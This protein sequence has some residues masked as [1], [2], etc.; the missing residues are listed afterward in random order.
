MRD[1][2]LPAIPT[3]EI[4]DY[5]VKME[6]KAQLF[7]LEQGINRNARSNLNVNPIYPAC[8]GLDNII[9]ATSTNAKGRDV[10]SILPGGK[11]G[12]QSGTSI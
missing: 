10:K 5:S 9:S 8:F 3:K 12:L 4:I 6:E 2:N 11:R 1:I 7:T